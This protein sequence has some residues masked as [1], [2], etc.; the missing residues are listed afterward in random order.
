MQ[1]RFGE[2]WVGLPQLFV[3][4]TLT[5]F[6]KKIG[7]YHSMLGNKKT[8]DVGKCWVW[9]RGWEYLVLGKNDLPSPW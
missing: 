1:N 7:V 5:A 6:G 3:I 8:P 9:L 4:D 2:N